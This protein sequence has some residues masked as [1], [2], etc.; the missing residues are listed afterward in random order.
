MQTVVRGAV[1]NGAAYDGFGDI[2][3]RP[4]DCALLERLADARRQEMERHPGKPVSLV[5]GVVIVEQAVRRREPLEHLPALEVQ[6]TRGGRVVD[7]LAG[8]CDGQRVGGQQAAQTRHG[9]HDAIVEVDIHC[10]GLSRFSCFL[11]R[12]GIR[13]LASSMPEIKR[14]N[15]ASTFFTLATSADYVHREAHSHTA[16]RSFKTHTHPRCAQ[17]WNITLV[18]AL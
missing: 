1:L 11:P 12:G 8:V 13:R 7:V 10:V 9:V 4:A 5:E 6:Q 2:T 18:V 15:A 17:R 16:R 3:V 14:T